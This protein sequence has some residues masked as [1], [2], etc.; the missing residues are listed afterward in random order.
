MKIVYFAL[1]RCIS[2]LETRKMN[3]EDA[4]QAV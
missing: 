3:I 4:K 1:W 2:F